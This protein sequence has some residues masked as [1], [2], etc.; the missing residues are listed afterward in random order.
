MS[1]SDISTEG[2]TTKGKTIPYNGF[3]E[4]VYAD[5]FFHE[6]LKDKLVGPNRDFKYNIEALSE[7]LG[8]KSSNDTT[9]L[10]N[11]IKSTFNN[12]TRKNTE[13]GRILEQLPKN[14]VSFCAVIVDAL[15]EY[16]FEYK[17]EFKLPTSISKKH[18][19]ELVSKNQKGTINPIEKKLLDN[20]LNIK[21]CNCI[22]GLIVEDIVA[23]KSNKKSIRRSP[24]YNPYA[25]CISS[26]YKKRNIAVPYQATKKCKDM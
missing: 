14:N 7:I 26:V 12:L 4:N 9:K 6:I 23:E 2:K 21:L 15:Y 10:C 3:I 8:V 13:L 19:N 20:I 18:Y 5:K 22:K 24:K 17:R 16:F 1:A 25:V 11:H